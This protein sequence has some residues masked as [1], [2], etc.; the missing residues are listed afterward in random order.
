MTRS[1]AI[2]RF[3]PLQSG[4][5]RDLPSPRSCAV[6][7]ACI[8][9][10]TLAIPVSSLADVLHAPPW[11]TGESESPLIE[12]DYDPATGTGSRTDWSAG[13]LEVVAGGFSPPGTV[14]LGQARA[15]AAKTAR[16]LAFEKLL[17][18]G[19]HKWEE[20]VSLLPEKRFQLRRQ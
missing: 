20:E 11:P 4:F 12:T 13:R 3:T 15:L 14:N 7:F 18:N 9:A 10:L 6:R 8:L 1:L 2:G 19:L 5:T 16:H 17:H